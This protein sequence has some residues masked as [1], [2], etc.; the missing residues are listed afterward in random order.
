MTVSKG[1]TFNG[2]PYD[3]GSYR[4]YLNHP[5]FSGKRISKVVFPTWTEA[6]GQDDLNSDWPNNCKG[7]YDSQNDR[8]VFI[9]KVMDHYFENGN[10]ITHIYMYDSNGNSLYAGDITAPVKRSTPTISGSDSTVYSDSFN[11]YAKNVS[12]DGKKVKNVVF[13]TWTDKNGQDDLIWEPG[14]YDVA[15]DRWVCTIN[16]GSHKNENGIYITHVYI[17][18][19]DGNKTWLGAKNTKLIR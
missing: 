16:A 7:T 10:Y 13:P 6:N 14:V 2:K 17:E 11:V 3:G 4:I 8:W 1:A 19:T 5:K 9:V 12:L 15:S 18:D